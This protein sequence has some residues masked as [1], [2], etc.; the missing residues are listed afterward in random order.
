MIIMMINS[1]LQHHH[2]YLLLPVYNGLIWQKASLDPNKLYYSINSFVQSS[3]PFIQVILNNL[4]KAL[5][6]F[7]SYISISIFY[8]I[9]KKR[10]K[11][12]TS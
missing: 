6:S 7:L 11:K 5:S 2:Q 1:T 9:T 10:K 4:L 8:V 12:F 3:K